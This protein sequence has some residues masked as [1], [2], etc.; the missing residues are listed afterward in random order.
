[1]SKYLLKIGPK[2]RSFPFIK[3]LRH[4]IKD[5]DEII[6]SYLNVKDLGKLRDRFEGQSFYNNKSRIIL[7]YLGVCKHLNIVPLDIKEIDLDLFVPHV[8]Y[9]G[10]RYKIVVSDFG[11]FPFIEKHNPEPFIF[12][13][14]R[15][16]T[17]FSIAGYCSEKEL[18]KSKNFIPHNANKMIFMSIENLISI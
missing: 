15:S 5:I 18:K 10:D 1:M 11:E 12:V 9:N 14:A 6:L 17:E 2:L 7:A 8:N 16:N 13:I 4:Q 3:I